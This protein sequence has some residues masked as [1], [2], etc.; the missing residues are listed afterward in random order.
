MV[1]WNNPEPITF[2]LTEKDVNYRE[3]MTSEAI[4]SDEGENNTAIYKKLEPV[5]K[6]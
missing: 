2:K 4:S 1:Y 6:D 3:N 5:I